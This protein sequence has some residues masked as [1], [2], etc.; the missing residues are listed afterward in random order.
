MSLFLSFYFTVPLILLGYGYIF[1]RIILKNNNHKIDIGLIGLLGFL[2]LYLI[3]NITHFFINFDNSLIFII[4]ILG[5]IF[6]LYLLTSSN[7]KKFDLFKL[8]FLSIIFLPIAIITEPNED[9]Y[10]Y[11]LPYLKYLES[12]KII[13]GL[14][15]INDTLAYSSNSFYDILVLFKY[16]FSFKN[17]YSIPIFFFYIFYLFFII[18]KILKYNDF[19]YIF[20]FLLS[21]IS[22]TSL[23]DFGTSIP[24]QL[25]LIICACLIYECLIY[26]YNENKITFVIV[27]IT[28]A[29]ILRINSILILPLFLLLIYFYYKKIPNYIYNNIIIVFTILLI[30]I[31]FLGKNLIQSSCLVYPIHNTCFSNLDWSTDLKIVNQKYSKLQADSKGWSFYAKENFNIKDK[32][33]WKNLNKDNFIEYKDY[34]TTTPFFWTKYWI[35]DPNYKKIL[36]L[37]LSVI[38]IYFLLLINSKKNYNSQFLDNKNNFIYLLSFS[39]F[40]CLA[41][42]Y[43]SPQIRYGGAFCFIFFF[44]ISIKYI[45]ENLNRDIKIT[46]LILIILIVFSYVEY[47]NFNRIYS[48]FQN[49]LFDNFP[50]PNFHELQIDNDFI[51]EEK[52]RIKFNK[53]I[54]SNKL[55]FDNN[56]DY[57]LMCGNIDFPC[58][59]EGKEVC[60]NKE[61]SKYGYLFYSHNKDNDN[62]YNFMNKNILY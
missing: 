62:C 15:N 57:I 17:S 2:F 61:K 6:F 59:P 48:S 45:N 47:K 30:V 49:E 28:L 19:F 3:S 58:I 60:L 37:F 22:F 40:S 13:F 4:Q 54:Y 42:F 9:F 25:A 46:N 5:I 32:Y 55:L 14:V 29:I 7:I 18:N 21:L 51:I 38:I 34:A 44:S 52:N 10:H 24:P 1:S 56:N 26:G 50:W 31:F 43:L 27:L 36:N 23:R 33:V 11:Y 39:F 53:R 12:S 20:I 8:L 35:K 16:P 41:W